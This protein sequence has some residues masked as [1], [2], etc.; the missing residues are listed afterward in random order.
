MV[1][2]LTLAYLI[3]FQACA[4]PSIVRIVRRR[5]SADLSAW[6]EILLLVGVSC[7]FAVMWQTGAAWQVILSPVASGTSIA[8]LLALIWRYRSA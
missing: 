3:L 2:L 7:Q 6:R 8:V 5:H 4:W 1:N